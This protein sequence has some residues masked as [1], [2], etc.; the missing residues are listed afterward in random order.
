M[1]RTSIS[2]ALALGIAAVGSGC[3]TRTIDGPVTVSTKLLPE[4]SRPEVQ[5]EA[6]EVTGTSCGRVLLSFIPIGVATAESAYADAL[7]QAPGADTLIRYESRATTLV[8][9]PFYVEG[10]SVVH[11]YAVSSKSLE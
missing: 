5:K 6:K 1:T 10:C 9:W 3:T 7:A 8:L 2:L 11:G 4:L